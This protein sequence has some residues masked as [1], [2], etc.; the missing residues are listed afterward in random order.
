MAAMSVANG[1]F[2][3]R[4][5][6]VALLTGYLGEEGIIALE[7]ERFMGGIVYKDL[8]FR[9]NITYYADYEDGFNLRGNV[10]ILGLSSETIR[11]WASAETPDVN[12]E[13]A[14]F[15]RV[16]A[17]YN[18]D[19]D[20]DVTQHELFTMPYLGALPTMPPE[21][22]L[23]FNCP[24]N[25]GLLSNRILEAQGGLVSGDFVP[26]QAKT[27][28]RVYGQTIEGLLKEFV[29]RLNYPE[30]ALK[31]YVKKGY[32][33]KLPRVRCFDFANKTSREVIA[34][35]NSWD[36]VQVSVNVKTCT[37]PAMMGLTQKSF[38]RA[39]IEVGPPWGMGRWGLKKRPIKTISADSGM[40]GLPNFGDNGNGTPVVSVKTLLRKDIIIN[41]I[42]KVESR[43][44]ESPYQYYRVNQINYQGEFRGQPWYTTYTAQRYDPNE[45]DPED[46]EDEASNQNGGEDGNKQ[47][48]AAEKWAGRAT[49]A[50]SEAAIAIASGGAS[51]G[52]GISSYLGGKAVNA[53]NSAL[54]REPGRAQR[55]PY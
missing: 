47:E 30:D 18:K 39:F 11:A 16:Y 37:A 49:R 13:K 9:F 28:D 6:G 40:I 38:L 48:T 41:D 1:D 50:S 44:M 42:I 23:N 24:N 52:T 8:N 14:R 3:N 55:T 43:F 20:D 53:I 4:V 15:I 21:M 19:G 27:K 26:G 17:G 45:T 54:G 51:L 36:L 34:E 31:F 22:W 33:N 12:R 35:I 25:V 7:T 29:K 2:Y 46:K 5:G 32:L 10:G